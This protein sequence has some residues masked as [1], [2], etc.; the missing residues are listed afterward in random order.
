MVEKLFLGSLISQLHQT[1][2]LVG[3]NKS[4]GGNINDLGSEM[5]LESCDIPEAIEGQTHI[6][7][8]ACALNECLRFSPTCT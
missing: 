1:L 8:Y 5:A 2:T 7:D 4:L 6:V 3:T